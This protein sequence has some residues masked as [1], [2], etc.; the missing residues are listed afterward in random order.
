MSFDLSIWRRSPT[1]KTAMLHDV[2]ETVGLNGADHPAAGSFDPQEFIASAVA[3][4]GRPAGPDGDLSWIDVINSDGESAPVSLWGWR[5]LSSA[6]VR[7]AGPYPWLQATRE[8]LL[9]LILER[10]LMLYDPQAGAVFNNR[11]SYD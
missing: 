4:N 1:T 6:I 5:G 2:H 10:H 11:R 9:P 3:S 7:V 8:A